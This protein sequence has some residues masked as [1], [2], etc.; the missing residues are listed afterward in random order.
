LGV[1]VGER[2]KMSQQCAIAALKANHILDCNKRNMISRLR[3]VVLP[4]YSALMRPHLEF[5]VQFWGSQHKKHI[6]LLEWVQRRATQTTG[7]LEHLP[8]EDRL[9]ELGHF[10]LKN[11]EL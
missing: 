7:G 9:R 2:L 4:L 3:E 10:S 1:S 11:R 8:C 5:C 6:E